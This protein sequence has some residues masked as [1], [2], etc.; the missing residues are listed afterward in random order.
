MPPSA[1]TTPAAPPCAS[2]FNPQDWAILARHWYP[3][4]RAQDVQQTPVTARLLDV[5][6]VL[7]R[8]SEG[9]CVARDVCPH[10]GVPL[11]MGRLDGDA[12]VCAYHG[13]R[14]GSDGRCRKIPAQPELKPAARLNLTHYPAIERY[15]LIWTCLAPD[16]ASETPPMP[17]WDDPA[18]QTIL[19]EPVDIAGSAG[20]QVEGFVDVAHF[21]FVHAAAFAD[22]DNSVVPSY[23]TEFTD[24]GL[25]THYASTVS[26]YPQG[27]QHLAPPDF[28]W[29]RV[30]EV[31]P[32][33]CARLTVHFPDGGLLNILNT[34]C[35]VS[36]TRTRLFVPITRNFD[37]SSPLEPVYA[38]NAQIFAEDQALIERQWPLQLPLDPHE[39]AHFAAD[40]SSLGYRRLLRE[41]GLS[42]K[43]ASA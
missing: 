21:A 22:P 3:V 18:H 17:S 26:N 1:T 25:R 28:V 43:P 41:M 19:P 16:E 40:R 37:T 39:E 29:L 42:F 8:T 35:P 24:F 5:P 30:F 6:L 13:L 4:A 31:Y 12:L 7:F 38:F 10:R 33:F 27:L 14:F 36:A 23:D 15:G 20:R 2:S 9:L 11:S 34:A 32:P